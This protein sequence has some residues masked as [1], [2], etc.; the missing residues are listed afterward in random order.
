MECPLVPAVKSEPKKPKKPKPDTSAI[1]M[2][3][4]IIEEVDIKSE[5]ASDTEV[6]GQEYT[7]VD[8][9]SDHDE[10]RE[11][12]V[13]SKEKDD[14]K[15]QED[16][17]DEEPSELN[18]GKGHPRKDSSSQQQHTP[19]RKIVA[20]GG[21]TL[22]LINVERLGQRVIDAAESGSLRV[23]YSLA[24]NILTCQSQGLKLLEIYC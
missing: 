23:R 17:E 1:P 24:K 9:G 5:P 16:L 21:L 15:D 14:G 11:T 18:R 20:F 4:P 22:P 10:T 12:V 13:P 2:P 6:V 3:L 7:P 8:P 19:P